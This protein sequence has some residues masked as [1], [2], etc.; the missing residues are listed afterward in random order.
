MNK[1]M[2]FNKYKNSSIYYHFGD[3]RKT[4]KTLNRVYDVI[5]LDAFSPQKD[6]T[7]WTI[8]FLSEVKQK[9]K[10]DSIIVSY[11]KSTP[12][13]SALLELNFFVGKTYINEIDMGT[14]ASLNP[15][16]IINHLTDY[17]LDLISTRSGITYKDENLTLSPMEILKQREIEQNTSKRIS[18]TAFLKQKK[19]Q[20]L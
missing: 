18:Q 16:N 15:K 9:M 8:D 3:A 14:V 1:D 4:I 7:L 5:F 2:L 20:T 17:D 6:P 11:S 13:R 12:F 19:L 10:D